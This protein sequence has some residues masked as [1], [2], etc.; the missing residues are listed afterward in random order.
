MLQ[1]QCEKFVYLDLLTQASNI[2]NN[3]SLQMC[4]VAAFMIGEIFT[5]L[6]RFL[7]PFM[8]ISSLISVSM[9]ISLFD[10]RIPQ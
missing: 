10:H 7:K 8:F 2:E 3:K 5:N 9:E 1:K 6:G 4:Y